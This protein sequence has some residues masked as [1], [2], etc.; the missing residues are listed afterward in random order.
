VFLR[1]GGYRAAIVHQGEEI[2]YTV[3]ML[4]A[5]FVVRLGASDPIHHFE[6]PSRSM[7]RVEFYFRRNEILLSM[8][9]F[10]A[11]YSL[12]AAAGYA[13]RGIYYGAR[14]GH[15]RTA[16]AGIR[17]GIAVS[18]QLRRERRPIGRDTARLFRRLRRAGPL[19]LEE[20]EGSL[21]PL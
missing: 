15:G 8:T 5:G 1:L 6:S 19:R 11:P 16:L 2:D 9:Y 7:R 13:V 12:V 10:H 18:W 17:A 21:A 4:Q 20:I 3:R 14:V